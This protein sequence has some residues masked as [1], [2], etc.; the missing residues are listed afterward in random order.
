MPWRSC[1][2]RHTLGGMG[3]ALKS[4]QLSQAAKSHRERLTCAG[5]S[6]QSVYDSPPGR[7]RSVAGWAR[8]SLGEYHSS[9]ANRGRRKRHLEGGMTG[10]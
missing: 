7:E 3:S 8:V 9:H 4:W 6:P 10:W 5:S 1:G 2:R